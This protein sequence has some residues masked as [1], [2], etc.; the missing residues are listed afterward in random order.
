MCLSTF[1]HATRAIPAGRLRLWPR[2]EDADLLDTSEM[3]ID[4]AIAAAIELIERKLAA[5]A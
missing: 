4:E 5:L 3:A 1:A 2:H